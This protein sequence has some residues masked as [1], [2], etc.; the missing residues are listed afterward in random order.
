MAI[1]KRYK[2]IN[3]DLDTKRLEAIFGENKRRRAYA[4][5][6]R[7][8]TNHGFRHRQWSGYISKEKLNYAET[9]IVIDD[10]LITCPWLSVCTNRFDV[11][12]YV[13]ESDALDYIVAKTVDIEPDIDIKEE[14]LAF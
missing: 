6:Q 1:V 10:L 13:A 4:K 14:D 5:I 12:D 8:M 2:S 11:T 9:Y 3:F 7:F